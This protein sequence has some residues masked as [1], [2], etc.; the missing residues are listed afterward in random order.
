LAGFGG[1][2]FT[3]PIAAWGHQPTMPVIGYLSA[4]SSD[5][6]TPLRVPFLKSLE[7]SGFVVG[8]D[9]AIEYRFAE[10]HESRLPTLAAEL[11]HRKVALLAAFG[12]PQALAAKAATTTVPIIFASGR[13]PVSDGLVV[14]LHRPGGNATGIS[15]LTTELGPKRLALLREL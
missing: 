2:A 5:A 9:L 7:T 4:R 10:G 1:A 15:A 8:R 11:L 13:D 3:G 12:W 6:E 14:S